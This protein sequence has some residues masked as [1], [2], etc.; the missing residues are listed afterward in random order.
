[1][2]STLLPLAGLV[3]VAAVVLGHFL[4]EGKAYLPGDVLPIYAP[5][6]VN[7]RPV[8]RNK[9]DADPALCT[10]PREASIGGELRARRGAPRWEPGLGAGEP[11][12]LE[13]A[14][15]PD[16]PP[17]RLAYALLPAWA[18]HATILLL[19]LS[20]ALAGTFLLV[21]ARGGSA[22]A[23]LV[24]ALVAALSGTNQSWLEL[25]LWTIAAA[26][27]PWALLGIELA[28]ARGVRW[29]AV[30]GLA[31]G[32]AILGGHLQVAAL[33]LALAP[34]YALLLARSGNLKSRAL[35]A[36]VPIVLGLA[37]GSARLVPALVELGESSRERIP[38]DEYFQDTAS[39][40]PSRLILLVAPE[41]LGDPVAGHAMPR[42][43][44][45]H[46]ANPQELRFSPG[47]VALALAALAFWRRR[48]YGLA[49]IAILLLVVCLPT[50][51]AWPLW[52]FAPGFGSTAP[53]RVL[54]LFPLVSALLAAEGF[55]LA[56]EKPRTLAFLLFVVADL[57]AGFTLAAGGLDPFLGGVHRGPPY[58]G[59]ALWRPIWIAL[60]AC[61]PL[62]ACAAATVAGGKPR[63]GR[64]AGA[65]LVGLIAFDLVEST[66]RWNPVCPPDALYPTQPVLEEAR[67]LAGSARVLLDREIAPDILL[68]L[69]FRALGSYGSS[70]P[71]R[72][73]HLVNA[74]A[75]SPTGISARQWIYARRLPPAW[76]DAFS[77]RAVL[78][79]PEFELT[80]PAGLAPVASGCVS[81]F[82]NPSALPRARF[83][84]ALAV[85]TRPDEAGALA[86]VQEGS[87]DPR[88]TLVV[89][90][91]GPEQTASTRWT[92][93]PGSKS[94]ELVEDLP[95]RVRLRA[96][97][98][99]PGYVVLAD[100]FAA[101]WR[102]T[103]DGEPAEIL[104]ADVAF[105]A[106]W[107]EPG[108]HEVVFAFTPPGWPAAPLVSVLATLVSLAALLGLLSKTQG[109]ENAR[110]AG[111][112]LF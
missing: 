95:E 69:G 49:L 35:A 84:P 7:P 70:H 73:A 74:V 12:T 88:S 8:P 59:R 80:V 81:V 13:N 58:G 109:K 94:V 89:E 111:G 16:Y 90:K 93:P 66:L 67:T 51:L 75:P 55:E 112:P 18:A 65:A 21:R 61:V 64:C 41:I 33:G 30:S 48:N 28:L 71:G 45:E 56:R 57:L 42:G 9:L 85:S 27:L 26:L 24:G 36:L 20:L 2:R 78:L 63:L 40:T 82:A 77:V 46:H 110:S 4:L 10:F 15:A 34:V 62:A 6:R 44:D 29:L 5:F 107:V 97:V 102:A 39:L 32:G 1:V 22:G 108:E 76:R 54:A 17:W 79:D 38:F 106:V 99:F 104:P 19:H 43:P 60:G 100:T 83:V 37:I 105:R 101:G 23:G 87:F 3:L 68:P 72:F 91:P 98:P 103:V 50:P 92:T 96:N 52:R 25:D 11:I 47:A 86:L 14:T 53:T 31:L